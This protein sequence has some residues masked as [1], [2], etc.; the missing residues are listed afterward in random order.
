MADLITYYKL[1][2][3]GDKIKV[4]TATKV[5]KDVPPIRCKKCESPMYRIRWEDVP[6][7]VKLS[8]LSEKDKDAR[9]VLAF[10]ASLKYGLFPYLSTARIAERLR[11]TIEKISSKRSR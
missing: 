5:V 7:S 9:L 4:E 2:P 11:E 8:I 3:T 1:S 6:N 10:K